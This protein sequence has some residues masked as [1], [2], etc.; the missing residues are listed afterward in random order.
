MDDER[1]HLPR[2]LYGRSETYDP[3]EAYTASEE[4]ARDTLP[5]ESSPQD[6]EE[7]PESDRG[8]VEY[9]YIRCASTE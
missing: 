5:C 4:D 7:S 1:L 3:D 6:S 2:A 9:P 8:P